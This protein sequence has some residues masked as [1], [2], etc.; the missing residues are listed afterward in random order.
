MEDDPFGFDEAGGTTAHEEVDPFAGDHDDA[1]A[2]GY[3]A[4]GDGAGDSGAEDFGTHTFDNTADDF[5]DA[6]EPTAVA[7]Q[8]HQPPQQLEQ[9]SAPA[10]P[11]MSAENI[12][13]VAAAAVQDDDDDGAALR[14]FEAKWRAQLEEKESTNTSKRAEM[15]QAAAAELSQFYNNKE[16]SLAAKKAG[17]R[18]AEQEHQ[19]AL[20]GALASENPWE[21]VSTLVDMS[22]AGPEAAATA[23]LRNLLIQLK[24][25]PVEAK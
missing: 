13:S 7:D 9:S 6:V 20:A 25:A 22:G 17:N 14:V 8:Q 5:G 19:N 16:S 4:F 24:N 21:M 15:K 18:E 10:A 11:A 23:R 12:S 2:D 1:A 3:D